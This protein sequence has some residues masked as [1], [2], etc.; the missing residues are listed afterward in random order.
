MGQR[1]HRSFL[2][3]FFSAGAAGQNQRCEVEVPLNIVTPD[4]GLV[5]NMPQ[6]SFVAHHGPNALAI[7]SVNADSAPRRIVLV[8]EDG[9]NVNPAAR[10]VEVSILGAIL[11]K[12]RAEDSFAFLT[13]RG[14]RKELP[15]G[16]PRDAL[17][18]AIEGLSST[19]S[20]KNRAASAL[21]AVL[22]AASW[23]QP[24]QPGD[25]IIL[26]TMG[27]APSG[28]EPEFGRVGKALNAAGIRLF[29]YQLGRPYLGIYTVGIAH[30]TG[31]SVLPTATVDPN[32]ETIFEL[33]DKTGG[34]FLE[35][36]TEG[37][38]QREYSLTDERLRQVNKFAGQLYKGI[39]EYYRVRLVAAPEGFVIDLTDSVRQQ[40]L[41][42][43][44]VYPRNI[45][46][47][48]LH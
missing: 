13:A 38:P 1:W 16:T 30:S 45:R 39:A 7:S 46:P 35:E 48:S 15:F 9:K 4:V 3:L 6:E 40:L 36:N 18:S 14:L 43:R 41:Q 11:A 37:D 12:A 47:C 24:S 29:G 8:V 23:L 32:R 34:F 5:R 27:L 2:L 17:L 26:L 31:G 20:G 28:G 10:K 42:A 22:E 44:M 19:P 25:S 21:D 33:A